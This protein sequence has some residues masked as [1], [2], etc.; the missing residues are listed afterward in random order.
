[1]AVVTVSFLM[2][3]LITARKTPPPVTADAT[4][5]TTVIDT[6]GSRPPHAKHRHHPRV[7]SCCANPTQLLSLGALFPAQVYESGSN[8][9]QFVTRFLLKETANQIQSLLSSVESAVEAIE[10]QT[11]QIGWVDRTLQG[12]RG[13]CHARAGL[14]V[15]APSSWGTLA[16]CTPLCASILPAVPSLA[17]QSL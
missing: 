12:H 13:L 17:P 2:L 11:S 6:G 1:M 5:I 8:V 7:P 4:T 14:L 15:C 9:D 16:S 10:E 3:Y